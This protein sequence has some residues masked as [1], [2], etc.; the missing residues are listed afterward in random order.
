MAPDSYDCHAE[1][2]GSESTAPS[3]EFRGSN[4]WAWAPS[5]EEEY[6]EVDA[7]AHS[8]EDDV[9]AW[10]KEDDA[11][12]RSEEDDAVATSNEGMNIRLPVSYDVAVHNDHKR[13]GVVQRTKQAGVQT[14]A[15]RVRLGSKGAKKRR[16]V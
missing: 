4:A 14:C 5:A 2:R 13:I 11:V 9:V 3:M 7:R 16:R 8:F 10:S 12:A 1:G 15:Q 6:G